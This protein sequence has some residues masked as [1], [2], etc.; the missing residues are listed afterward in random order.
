MTDKNETVRAIIDRALSD[1]VAV[2]L[3]PE[4]SAVLLAV[5]GV[6]RVECREQLASIAL[7]ARESAEAFSTP[8][9]LH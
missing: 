4:G 2:G 5:Q 8:E 9:S 7:L 3:T 6:I 1:L